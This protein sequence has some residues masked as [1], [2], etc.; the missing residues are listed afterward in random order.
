M[1]TG[2][3]VVL[4]NLTPAPAEFGPGVL[5]NARVARSGAAFGAGIDFSVEVAQLNKREVRELRRDPSVLSYARSM[6]VRLIEPQRL[7]LGAAADEQ[8][9]TWGVKAVGADRSPYSGR[10]VRVAVLDTGIDAR[11]D[12]FKGLSIVE[13]DL[14]LIHF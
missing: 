14:S 10:G 9:V 11:H 12:A 2:K 7:G 13:Q 8:T 4:R 5:A 1:E 6:P 3:F